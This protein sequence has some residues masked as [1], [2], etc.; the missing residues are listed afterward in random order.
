[1]SKNAH[2]SWFKNKHKFLAYIR[3][4]SSHLPIYLWPSALLCFPV[5]VFRQILAVVA[6]NIV[7]MRYA[8]YFFLTLFVCL[9]Y[10]VGLIYLTFKWPVIFVPI[11]LWILIDLVFMIRHSLKYE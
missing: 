7:Q 1:M 8:I 6:S 9:C 2:F 10:I 11:C 5:N 4:M 3:L